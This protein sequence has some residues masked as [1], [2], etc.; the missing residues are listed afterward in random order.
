MSCG[1]GLPF[2]VNVIHVILDYGGVYLV[3]LQ[4]DVANL[5]E[6]PELHFAPVDLG[7]HVKQRWSN[8]IIRHPA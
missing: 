3:L 7:G 5:T 2:Q 8:S 4:D 6:N 1:D